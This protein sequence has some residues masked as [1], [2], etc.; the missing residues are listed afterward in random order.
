MSDIKENL[1]KSTE[2][3]SNVIESKN[4]G[5]GVKSSSDIRKE[6][7][8]PD[9]NFESP[10]E[11]AFNIYCTDLLCKM[12]KKVLTNDTINSYLNKKNNFVKTLVKKISM[13]IET[14][15]KEKLMLLQQT[16]GTLS[17]DSDL[18]TDW[19]D[20]TFIKELISRILHEELQI[21][22]E[23]VKK[24]AKDI[25]QTELFVRHRLNHCHNIN[26]NAI[27]YD[28]ST[29]IVQALD[30]FK[31]YKLSIINTMKSSIK[32]NITGGYPNYELIFSQIWAVITLGY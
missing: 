29:S 7:F 22:E 16:F 15:S 24:I 1:F 10:S 5:I 32:D 21:N 11:L 4:V 26:Y 31:S 8:C 28:V 9:F 30:G 25:K 23:T 17:L 19:P 18:N 14:N 2:S 3:T 12:R 13:T 27:V 20:M 6:L